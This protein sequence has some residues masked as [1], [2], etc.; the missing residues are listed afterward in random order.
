MFSHVRW[1]TDGACAQVLEGLSGCAKL[2]TVVI[3][4]P[5]ALST[6]TRSKTTQPCLLR[7][8]V[9][10]AAFPNLTTVSRHPPRPVD[11]IV[12]LPNPSP[13]SVYRCDREHAAAAMSSLHDH[14]LI[15]TSVHAKTAR[16]TLTL[17]QPRGL[18]TATTISTF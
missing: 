8:V 10:L 2:G 11:L 5:Q 13:Q 18:A 15:C 14:S 12:L 7:T 16:L 4:G 3:R 9:A 6:R 1:E 17:E